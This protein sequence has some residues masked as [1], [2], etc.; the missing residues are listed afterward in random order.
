MMININQTIGYGN[1]EIILN[2]ISVAYQKK[3]A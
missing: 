2:T 1:D 3:V